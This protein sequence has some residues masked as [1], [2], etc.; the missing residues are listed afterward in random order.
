MNVPATPL[1]VLILSSLYYPHAGG[2]ERQA[3]ALARA[4]RGQ[5]VEVLVLTCAVEG[6][7]R[8]ATID[9]VPV[10]RAIR[11]LALGPLW[12]LTYMLSTLWHLLRLR[13]QY[14]L[15][16]CQ[17]LYL[18]GPVAVSC[19]RWLQKPVVIRLACTRAY[20]DVAVMR[21]I[22]FGRLLLKVAARACRFVALSLEGQ[23]EAESIGVPPGNITIIPNPV[24]LACGSLALPRPAPDDMVLFV[25]L[26]RKQKGIDRLL[27]AFAQLEERWC[28]CLVGDGP[29]RAAL[30]R[31]AIGLNI[32]DRVHFVGHVEDPSEYYARARLFVLPS[33]AEGLSNALLEAMAFGR[34]VVAT[35][36]GGNVDLIQDGVN[37]LLVE[38]DSPDEM[39]E[40]MSRLLA[41]EGFAQ[42]MGANARK[43]VQ[44]RYT[45]SCVV[46]Q[47][48]EVYRALLAEALAGGRGTTRPPR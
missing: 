28:L 34:P 40:A 12:G 47:Y 25:G 17:Q 39:A 14:D 13:R 30:E 8:F 42:R 29:E 9:G 6:E 1:R 5:G 19:Q 3:H 48:L 37:G 31:R 44:E 46:A 21:Q 35:H 36:I 38:P 32:A 7:R 23:M 20:G 10:H 4:L 41:N 22:R 16:H 27:Q 24:L 2:A 33:L 15:I 43:T 45:M 18:H 11:T 26:L